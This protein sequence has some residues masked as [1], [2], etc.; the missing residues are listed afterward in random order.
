MLP[1]C[2]YAALYYLA[3]LKGRHRW[4]RDYSHPYNPHHAM[5]AWLKRLLTLPTRKI[6]ARLKR[7]R[8]SHGRYFLVPL[9]LDRDAQVMQHSPYPRV[10]D[11][12]H[13]VTRSFAR[14]APRDHLLIFKNHP[15]A[16]GQSRLR[17]HV[18]AAALTCGISRRVIF[19][20]AGR[21]PWFITRAKGVI[22]INSTAGLSALHHRRPTKALGNAIY[23]MEGLTSQQP[24][25][26]F[27]SNPTPPDNAL[28]QRM[29]GWLMAR[30]QINGSFYNKRGRAILTKASTDRL[31][32][33]TSYTAT[34]VSL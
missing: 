10:A 25:D 1:M 3:C 13:E 9:Q 11:F 20:P 24:L 27:W 17:D 31:T 5:R 26:E 4:Y 7:L 12:V 16:D 2:Y 19:I 22:V 6:E 18:R 15:L 33:R 8:Y 28:F 30:T 23:N 14:H 21:L 32:G 29:R 34:Q